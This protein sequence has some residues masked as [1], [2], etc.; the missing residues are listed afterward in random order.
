MLSKRQTSAV[1][2]AIVLCLFSVGEAR[3][4]AA[5]LAD[6]DR[7]EISLGGGYYLP[8]RAGFR[9]YYRG[10]PEAEVTASFRFMPR[11]SARVDFFFTRL[12]E[13]KVSGDLKFWMFSIVPSIKVTLPRAHQPYFGAGLGYYRGT[14]KYRG[15][16][17]PITKGEQEISKGGIGVKIYSGLKSFIVGRLFLAIEGRYCHTFLGDPYKGDFGNV[18]GFSALGKLGISF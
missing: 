8:T 17:L 9:E 18:G 4:Q 6:D 5:P 2:A 7:W 1:L 12:P 13:N 3:S 14:V 10:G 15:E 11:L 16:Y